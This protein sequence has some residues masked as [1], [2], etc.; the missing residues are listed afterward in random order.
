MKP[1]LLL[2]LMML[3]I[4]LGTVAAAANTRLH[5]SAFDNAPI[6]VYVN[7]VEYGPF[8]N[9]H[10]LAN[11]QP[12]HHNLRVVALYTNPYSAFN[13]QQQ[14]YAGPVSI[15][16]GFETHVVINPN[17]QLVVTNMVALGRPIGQPVH[18]PTPTPVGTCGTPVPQPVGNGWVA[19][20]PTAHLAVHPQEFALMLQTIRN[21]PFDNTRMQVARQII[22]QNFFTTAQAMQIVSLF[23]FERSRLEVA[24]FAYHRTVDQQNYFLMYDVFS[25]NSSVN[26]L[27]RY[28]GSI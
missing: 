16:H 26:E 12:G 27:N 2:P 15:N 23:S 20:F 21:R 1:R 25:F 13:T 9:R 28:I 24:K 11:L 6:V 10:K 14:I 5:L 8:S 18:F 7:G 4:L 3:L 19:P 17:N 22:S